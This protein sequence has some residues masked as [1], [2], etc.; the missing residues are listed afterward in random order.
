MKRFNLTPLKILRQRV[1][2]GARLLD[3]KRPGWFKKVK[4]T[5]LDMS[6]GRSCILG[7]AYLA[8]VRDEYYNGYIIGM[9]ELEVSSVSYGFNL[10]P[11]DGQYQDVNADFSRLAECWR[12]EI[13]KRRAA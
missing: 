6:S 3:D 13:R 1:R 9:R 5:E 4:M 2:A 11:V 10:V 8:E 7:Q 12:D